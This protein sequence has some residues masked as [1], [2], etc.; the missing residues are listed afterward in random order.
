MADTISADEIKTALYCLTVVAGIA[1]VYG[2]LTGNDIVAV[3][4]GVI[5]GISGICGY[6]VGK[7]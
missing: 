6:Q 3:F 2:F 4:T 5:A 1:A 7:A